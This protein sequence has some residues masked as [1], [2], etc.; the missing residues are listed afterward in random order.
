MALKVRTSPLASG[1]D[2]LD[3][4]LKQRSQ[5]FGELLRCAPSDA[6]HAAGIDDREVALLVCGAQLAEQVESRIDHK[7]RPVKRAFHI[8]QG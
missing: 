5:V 8:M 2:L 7:V 3:D 1:T 6:I 4:G